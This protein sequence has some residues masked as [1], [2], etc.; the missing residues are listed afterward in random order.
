METSLHL[1][2]EFIELGADVNAEDELGKIHA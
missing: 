1:A 2:E